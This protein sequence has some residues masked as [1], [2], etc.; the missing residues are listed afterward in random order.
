MDSNC[1]IEPSP[2]WW[3]I[4]KPRYKGDFYRFLRNSLCYNEY[5][6]PV[7]HGHFVSDQGSI[8]TGSK[9][10]HLLDPGAV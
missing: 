9:S 2:E 5:I 6:F 10:E 8:I 7:S 4:A 1:T 3:N